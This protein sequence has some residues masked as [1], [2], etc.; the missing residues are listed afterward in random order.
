MGDED[1]VVVWLS[2]KELIGTLESLTAAQ[3]GR[4]TRSGT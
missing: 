2:H 3:A 4:L 1:P